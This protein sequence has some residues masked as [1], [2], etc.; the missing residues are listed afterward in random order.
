MNNRLTIIAGPCSIDESNVSDIYNIA[1]ISTKNKAGHAKRAIAGTRVVGLKS[2]TNFSFKDDLFSGIDKESYLQN[3]DNFLS[4]RNNKLILPPSV[5]IAK[6]IMTDTNLLLV[7]EIVS[8][9]LQLPF[10]Q[11]FPK[12]KLLFWNPSINQLG[13]PVYETAKY[14]KTGDWFIGLKN[15]K[16]LGETVQ[17]SMTG[18][19]ETSME[20]AW[21]GLLSYSDME[22]ERVILIHRGV[23]VPEK[24]L[25]RN[26]PIHEAA[27]RVKIK[28]G[29]S[30]FFDPSH[31]FGPKLRNNIVDLTVE[32][33]KLK[34]SKDRYLYNGILIEVGQSQSDAEQHI[35]IKELNILAN[36]LSEFRHLNSPD[37]KIY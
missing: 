19:I 10:Y 5:R 6:K 36:M 7:S 16:W 12:N 8:P 27:K 21:R 33:M 15:G 1:K 11:D 35:S 37:E 9:L 2:R 20:T 32:A 24:G 29:C 22:K 3:L 26:L 18:K 34:A 30:L 13:W 25:H 14:C 17:Y 4:N 31:T 23:D 28:T